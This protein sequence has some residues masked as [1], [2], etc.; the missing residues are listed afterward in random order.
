MK[1]K[2][3]YTKSRLKR[4]STKID[5]INENML[6][7]LEIPRLLTLFVVSIK[8]G[9]NKEGDFGDRERFEG[10]LSYFFLFVILISEI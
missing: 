7:L 1:F 4:K 6:N 9:E 2:K 10:F 5:K 3:E 8:F